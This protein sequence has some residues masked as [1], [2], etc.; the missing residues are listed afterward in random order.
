MKVINQCLLFGILLTMSTSIVQ[1]QNIT[2]SKDQ[3]IGKWTL[4]SASYNGAAVSL[5]DMKQKITFEFSEEGLVTLI[6]PKGEEQKGM[7]A[8]K[9]NRLVDL[10]IPEQPDAHIIAL[11]EKGLV[12]EMQEETNKVMMTFDRSEE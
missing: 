3:I 6:T 4:K 8:I 11:S 7:F 9:D 2:F 12:L 5:A 10:T 1:A